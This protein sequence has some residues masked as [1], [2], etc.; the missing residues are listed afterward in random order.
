MYSQ[1]RRQ[2]QKDKLAL[3]IAQKSSKCH[4]DQKLANKECA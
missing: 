3:D 4:E 1:K 2:L